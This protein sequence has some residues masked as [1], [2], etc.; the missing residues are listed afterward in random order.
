MIYDIK[1][2]D[3]YKLLPDILRRV[4][5]RSSIKSSLSIFDTYDVRN[6]ETT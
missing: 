1:G 3:N 2:N 4:K 6:G 5:T